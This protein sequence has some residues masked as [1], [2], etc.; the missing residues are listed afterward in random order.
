MLVIYG[1]AMGGALKPW[2]LI[3]LLVVLVLI[4]GS[5]LVAIRGSRKR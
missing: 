2:H 5:V 1:C 4:I 3:C